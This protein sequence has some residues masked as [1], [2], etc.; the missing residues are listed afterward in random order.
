MRPCPIISLLKSV[1]ALMIQAFCSQNPTLS[2]FHIHPTALPARCLGSFPF[3][4]CI[5]MQPPCVRLLLIVPA[6]LRQ[7]AVLVRAVS[8]SRCLGL[9]FSSPPPAPLLPF[10]Q[11]ECGTITS[12]ERACSAW[13][14]ISILMESWE[15]RFHSVP[16]EGREIGS[17]LIRTSFP[18][19]QE[20][21]SAPPTCDNVRE[22]LVASLPEQPDQSGHSIAVLDGDLVVWI[23]AVRDVLER[24]AG[25]IVNLGE[26]YI[27]S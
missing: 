23:S 25:R 7:P 9:Q 20:T 24:A 6:Y 12:S 22:V 5:Y 26:P 8:H 14:T 11:P 4:S 17:T 13:S 19:Q 16:E 21:L 27:K 2:C 3:P 10:S 1:Y 15:D 18:S